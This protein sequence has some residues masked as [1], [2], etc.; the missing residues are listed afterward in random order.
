M[1]RELLPQSWPWPILPAH[2]TEVY[3]KALEGTGLLPGA[4][5][6]AV[7][8]ADID[9]LKDASTVIAAVADTTN[10]KPPRPGSASQGRPG[11]APIIAP[12]SSASP[13]KATVA[14]PAV[15]TQSE[16]QQQALM[17]TATAST[18]APQLPDPVRVDALLVT[19]LLLRIAASAERHPHAAA[20]VRLAPLLNPAPENLARLREQ[21]KQQLAATDTPPDEASAETIVVQP[22][23]IVTPAP[24]VPSSLHSTGKSRGSAKQLQSATG[25]SGAASPSATAAA[26]SS[27]TAPASTTS[28]SISPLGHADPSLSTEPRLAPPQ[29]VAANFVFVTPLTGS[30]QICKPLVPEPSHLLNDGERACIQAGGAYTLTSAHVKLTVNVHDASKLHRSLVE[31]NAA[32]ALFERLVVSFPYSED[33]TLH[34]LCDAVQV[35]K[36]ALG[37]AI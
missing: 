13:I 23:T 16:P 35:R 14:K 26:S 5:A 12:K 15:S 24:T 4:V 3:V 36:C 21:R 11:A 37:P 7:R 22:A 6:S 2:R 25:S 31:N 20:N 19:E 32:D 34:I 33:A 1:Q 8:V 30:Q 29:P 28:G 27:V 18:D 17:Q 9:D 10:G